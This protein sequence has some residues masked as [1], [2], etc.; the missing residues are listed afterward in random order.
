MDSW[1]T[2]LAEQTTILQELSKAFGQRGVQ[3][4]NYEEMMERV[5]LQALLDV[6]VDRGIIPR[7]ELDVRCNRIQ[8][9]KLQQALSNAAIQQSVQ[10]VAV[11][12][13]P[14]LLLAKR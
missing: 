1:E 5:K 14:Q 11:P 10:R 13:P 12:T 7:I 4:R 3:I 8:I 9:Q 6:L 2:E